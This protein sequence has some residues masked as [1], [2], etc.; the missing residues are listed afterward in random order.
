[1]EIKKILYL[2]LP[3]SLKFKSY[4]GILEMVSISK[5][6]T[7]ILKNEFKTIE[8]GIKDLLYNYTPILKNMKESDEY[9]SLIKNDHSVQTFLNDAFLVSR[10]LNSYSEVSEMI[11][12]WL[13]YG[14][15]DLFIK[16]HF[17]IFNLLKH[18][19]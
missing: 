17:D 3:Y 7:V 2:Y 16:H 5:D 12:E 14:V 8:I 19:S 13:P 1:M 4:E 9:F 15:L 6:D 11:T 10:G 18:K